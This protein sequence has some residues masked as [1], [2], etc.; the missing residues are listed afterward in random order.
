MF[1]DKVTIRVE[2]GTGGSGAEAFRRESGTPRG[3]PSGGDGGDG[4]DVVLICDPQ[5]GTLLDF[6]YRSE[7]RA[8]RGAHGEG[9]NRTGR[10]G[11]DMELRV[12]PGTVVKD[13]GTGELIGELLSPTERIVVAGGGRGGRGN[14]RFA[15][16]TRQAPR[17][18]EPGKPGESRTIELTLKLIA[19]VGLVGK[20]N[21]G[22]STLLAAVSAAR[23]KV[24]DYPFTTLAPH[25][26]V[27]DLSGFRSFVIADIP[28]II[29]GAHEGKGLGDRFLRHI[30]RTRVLALLI[31]CD[32]PRPQN[33]YDQLREELGRY[34]P[35]LSR[36]PH[37]V[38]LSKSD[39]LPREA[40]PPAVRA[41]EAWGTF[42][43]SA[44]ARRGIDELLEAFWDRLHAERQ[45]A[46]VGGGEG[47]VEAENGG[48]EKARRT[49]LAD[50]SSEAEEAWWSQVDE[51]P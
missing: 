33:T 13:A 44:V 30:E 19:D 36:R 28:G 24:A 23:P 17:H 27:V 49:Q 43:V 25:L 50:E 8:S 5:L 29:E 15:T 35:E 4:G 7:Y 26:G 2:G 9:S 38:V 37:C 20:P 39:L 6:R 16:P 3:G 48:E 32:D 41:P 1:I 45:T 18:W 12:P 11:E 47:R 10:R 46:D 31:P 22:K 40:S 51:E 21:A 34:S 42:V 14:A